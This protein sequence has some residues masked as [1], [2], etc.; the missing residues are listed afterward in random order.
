MGQLFSFWFSTRVKW[1]TFAVWTVYVVLFWVGFAD[2]CLAATDSS[3]GQGNEIVVVDINSELLFALGE[4]HELARE[5]KQQSV[6][7]QEKIILVIERII[8]G[9]TMELENCQNLAARAGQPFDPVWT[10]K[11]NRHIANF[12]TE[13]TVR[14]KALE[15]ELLRRKQHQLLLESGD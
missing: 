10:E 13:L 14:K 3:A 4:Y 2:Y 7:V 6:F 5:E 8:K 1:V 12:E 15:F 11:I 9:L